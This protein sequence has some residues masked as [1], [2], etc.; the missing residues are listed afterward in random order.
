MTK[1]LPYK[2]IGIP[3]SIFKTGVL[4]ILSSDMTRCAKRIRKRFQEDFE[5]W[6]VG[7]YEGRTLSKKGFAPIIWM[8][9]FPETV[10]GIACLSHEAFHATCRLLE[11]FNMPLGKDTEEMYAYIVDYIVSEVL[12]RQPRKAK[13]KKH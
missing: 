11:E 6:D 10:D 2:E 9:Q 12:R 3:I 1:R 13:R 7:D 4:V 5:E 8:K